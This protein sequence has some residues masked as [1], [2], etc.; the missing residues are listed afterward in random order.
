GRGAEPYQGRPVK[1][2]DDGRARRRLARA[3]ERRNAPLRGTGKKPL[4]Q[5]EW[6]RAGVVTK[7]MAYIAERENLGRKE[8]LERANGA[9]AEGESFGA[10]M[11]CFITPEFVREEVAR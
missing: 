2:G 10:S 1:P 3:F 8:M 9:L 7:E 11:P 4:T 5:L 6:A